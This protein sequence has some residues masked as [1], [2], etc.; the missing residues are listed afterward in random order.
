MS[1]THFSRYVANPEAVIVFEAGGARVRLPRLHQT[2][3]L[4]QNAA[5]LL[6]AI[7][8]PDPDMAIGALLE[9][10]TAKSIERALAVLRRHRLLVPRRKPS[11]AAW[12]EWGP[13]AWASHL[14]MRNVPFALSQQEQ[15]TVT[16]Q[17]AAT[18]PP[19]VYKCTCKSVRRSHRLPAPEAITNV[20]FT[21]VF[22]NRRTCR[23]FSRRTVS[24][25]ALS[26]VLFHAA[27]AVFELDTDDFGTVLLKCA[28]SPGARH[29]TEVYPLINRCGSLGRGLYHYCVKHHRLN[30]IS[31]IPK[32]F[33][34]KALLNQPYF[35][36]ASAVFFFTNVVARAMWKYR[37]SR[38]YRLLH[39]EVGHYCQNLLLSATALGLATFQTGAFDDAYIERALHADERTEFAM[40][41][42]GIGVERKAPPRLSRLRSRL[43]PHVPAAAD[44][45]NYRDFEKFL[46]H[47]T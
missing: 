13:L 26:T 33:L 19:S 41:V 11:R 23:N 47:R 34:R 12:Q 8:S 4:D 15:A 32:G 22:L 28:P 21:R 45:K 6:T 24:L 18:P 5:C 40:Y 7:A 25:Q 43:R 14:D 30:L 27:G 1:G 9:H 2:F 37:S 16:R 36:D 46:R 17:V 3:D 20:E 38:V 42:A 39:F 44:P 31:A 35:E 10:F 29:A